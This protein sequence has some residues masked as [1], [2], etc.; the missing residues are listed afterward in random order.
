MQKNNK[1]FQITGKVAR[2]GFS[3]LVLAGAL[4]GGA[5]AA[6]PIKVGLLLPYTGTYAASGEAATN[7][8]KLAIE[9]QGGKLGGREVEFVVVDSEADASKAVQNMQKLVSG[10][11]VDVVVGPMHSGVGMGALKVARE[12]GVPLIIPNAGFNAATGPLCAENVFRTSFSS[13]QTAYPMGKIAADKGYKN[14]VTV[15]WRYSFGTES[16]EGF[17]EGFEKAGGKIIKKIWLPFPDVEF[18]SQL[19]EIA[20][21]KPDAVFVF[22]AGGGA[23]KFVK[24]YAAAG[25]KDKIPL[26]GSGFLTE[27]TLAAQGPAAEGLLTTLHYADSLQNE[28]NSKFRGD[29]KQQFGKEADIYAVQGYDTGLLLAQS[30]EAVAGNTKDRAAWIKAMESARIDSPRGEWSFSKAHNPVQNIYLREVRNGTNMV[31]DVAHEKLSDP[32][33]GCKLK[34]VAA[35][36]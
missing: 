17:T 22:F 33:P 13:W 19:T 28:Q 18:Q 30:L 35:A 2:N 1:A 31:I 32:A 8:L 6:D 3:T 9:Q 27:G 20:A 24:D 23:A 26:L 15:T 7:G 12:S 5:Q 29:Y 25:L 16:V 4:S 10:A 34:Q 21:L 36:R 14:I 11:K